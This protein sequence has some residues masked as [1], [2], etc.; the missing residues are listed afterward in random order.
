[1]K[2]VLARDAVQERV[3]DGALERDRPNVSPRL[4]GIVTFHILLKFSNL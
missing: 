4:N 2:D 3:K 1:M